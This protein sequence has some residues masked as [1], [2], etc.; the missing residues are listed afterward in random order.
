MLKER[1]YSIESSSM[2]LGYQPP[3]PVRIVIKRASCNYVNEEMEVTSHKR[4]VFDRL[5]NKSKRTSVFDRIGS[6]SKNLKPPIYERLG[7]K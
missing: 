2:G 1:G 3:S 4:S 5:G 6:Q 7:N